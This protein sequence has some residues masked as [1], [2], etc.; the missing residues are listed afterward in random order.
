VA[1]GK[2]LILLIVATLL[3]V[4]CAQL[5]AW[6]YRA[7]MQQLMRSPLST[8]SGMVSHDR[9]AT[10][11]RPAPATA[12]TLADNRHAYRNLLTR[13]VLLTL[14][15]ALSRTLLTQWI[16]NAPMT[17]KTVAALGAAYA[18]PVLPVLAVINRWSRWRFVGVMLGWFVLAVLLMSW[19][20]N[21]HV[22][23]LMIL[24]WLAIDIGLPLLVVTILCL[25]GAT[26]A[27]GP[28]LAP[29]FVVLC[30]SSQA[31]LEGLT[32]LVH[33]QSTLVQWLVIWLG[34]RP[35]F[36]LFALLP[37]LLAWW[38]ARW[39]GRRLARAYRE[40]QVSELFYLFTAVW[41]IA[42]ISPTL[43]ASNTLGWRALVC[44]SP[45]LWIVL[46]GV[47]MRRQGVQAKPGRP[48]TLLVLRVFQQDANVQ[49]LFDRVIERWRL[50]GN[51]VLIAG[52]DLLDRTIDADDI[53]TFLDGRL[54]ERFVQTPADVPRR[55]AEFEWRADVDG[56]HRINE[57]YCHDSTWQQA[58]AEL[59][60][61][62]DV[63][64]MDLRNF[65]AHNRGCLHELQVLA[66]T[67]GLHRVVVLTNDQTELA[68][69]QAATAAAPAQRFVWLHQ[70]GARPLATE[71]VLAPLF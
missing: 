63:V 27:V 56:R 41:T 46:A 38:P 3:A 11:L 23:L 19:R 5:V 4:L 34:V 35:T 13:F 16:A 53:F 20:T 15:I 24:A 50:T 18:W 71:E 22:T 39:L 58:L 9:L 28:W 10:R 55:L 30:A 69:A 70:Q 7:R 68:T 21:E 66:E 40:Q 25:G 42:L 54:S 48:P 2:I 61:S 64:L 57:C 59:V 67:P 32:A 62:S 60:Q 36:T 1:S 26:R 51:T 52:T 29:V 65:V 37:W 49:N 45:L 17:V 44:F 47:W 8:A 31:G 33:A 12:L 43:A 14:V 6:R